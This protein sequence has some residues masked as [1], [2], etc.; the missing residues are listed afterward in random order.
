[1]LL[2]DIPKHFLLFFLLSVITTFLI[3]LK[4]GRFIE[5]ADKTY[6]PNASPS[7]IL[8]RPT[9][10]T[11]S[12]VSF[13]NFIQNDCGISF[14]YP[15]GFQREDI[16]SLE[17]VMKNGMQKIVVSCE[18]KTV[19]SFEKSF[20]LQKPIGTQKVDGQNVNIFEGPGNEKQFIIQNYLNGK[21]ALV[22]TTPE[23]LHLIIKTLEFLN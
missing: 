10:P 4:W 8:T 11:Q 20:S 17:A 19:S 18:E 13:A 3:G 16:S 15:K 2:K 23:L 7:P 9:S 6:I 12:P 14:L 5:K 21:F 22:K 1:M